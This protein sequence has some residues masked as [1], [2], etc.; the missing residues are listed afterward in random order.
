MRNR[1]VGE[2]IEAFPRLSY[3]NRLRRAGSEWRSFELIRCP[4]SYHVSRSKKTRIRLC[5]VFV[6]A[7]ISYKCGHNVLFGSETAG[8]GALHYTVCLGILCGVVVC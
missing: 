4:V 3:C 5:I 2:W 1:K 8:L 7:L 6:Y